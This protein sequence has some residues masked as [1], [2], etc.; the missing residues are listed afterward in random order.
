[1]GEI[2][3]VAES[4]P[5]GGGGGRLGFRR[6]VRVRVVLYVEERER[7]GFIYLEEG[8]KPDKRKWRGRVCK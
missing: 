5:K 6:E 4:W 8:P 3:E 7:N 1:M 2:L